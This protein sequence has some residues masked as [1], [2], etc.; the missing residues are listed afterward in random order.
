MVDVHLDSS[1]DE[2][3]RRMVVKCLQEIFSDIKSDVI[4]VVDED[5]GDFWEIKRSTIS[6]I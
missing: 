3:V 1:E 5:S 2:E 4:V 6:K